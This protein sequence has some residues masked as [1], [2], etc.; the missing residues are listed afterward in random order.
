M[1]YALLLALLLPLQAHAQ[2]LKDLLDDD[3]ANED[4]LLTYIG[5]VQH[6]VEVTL[7]SFMRGEMEGAGFDPLGADSIKCVENVEKISNCV[8]KDSA[9]VLLLKARLAAHEG[10]TSALANWIF[11][12]IA[13]NCRGISG[14]VIKD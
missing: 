11:E 10:K 7:L 14:P 6:G 5:G 13:Q 3:Y 4:W 1:R 8:H 2:E 9:K 12:T